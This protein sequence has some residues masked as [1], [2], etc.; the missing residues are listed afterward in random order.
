M[1][2]GNGKNDASR[3]LFKHFD[4]KCFNNGKSPAY[5]KIM[6]EWKIL[7]KNLPEDIYVQVYETRIDLLRAVIIGA[8]GTPY[9]D[10]LFFFDILLPSNYP[11]QPPSVYYHSH[12]YYLNPNLYQNGKVCLSL[13]NTWGGSKSERWTKESSILQVLVSIQ[14]LVLNERPYF[15]EPG[16]KFLS[17]FL[18]LASHEY[19]ENVFILSCLSMLRIMRKPPKNFEGFVAEHFRSRAA[20]I[21]TAIQNYQKG[22]MLIGQFQINGSSAGVKVSDQFRTKLN[23]IYPEFKKTFRSVISD[24]DMTKIE[25]RENEEASPCSSKT[26]KTVEENKDGIWNKIVNSVKNIMK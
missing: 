21:L 15:N 16:T 24:A 26:E 6:K 3:I 14:G 17:R 4:V 13:I 10:G 20:S 1:D 23:R 11:E 12:G 8:S 18:K 22:N 25:K 2:S 19:N 9:H 7:E 5:A